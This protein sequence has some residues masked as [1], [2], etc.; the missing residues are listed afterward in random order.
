MTSPTAVPC[1][2]AVLA[3]DGDWDGDW[4]EVP[5]PTGDMT[6]RRVRLSYDETF[7]AVLR[8][9]PPAAPGRATAVEVAA[10]SGAAATASGRPASAVAPEV[11]SAS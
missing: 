9:L 1:G 6:A 11:A 10:A 2:F 8:A 7:S 5:L 3:A 4:D